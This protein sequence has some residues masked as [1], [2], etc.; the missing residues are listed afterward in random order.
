MINKRTLEDELR[1]IDDFFNNLSNEEFEK[2]LIDCGAPTTENYEDA[3][4]IVNFDEIDNDDKYVRLS[5]N[6]KNHSYDSRYDSTYSGHAL[7]WGAA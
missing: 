6:Y 7:L 5:S 3:S 1:Y 4:R 2:M